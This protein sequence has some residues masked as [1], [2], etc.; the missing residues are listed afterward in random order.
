MQSIKVDK[1]KLITT[2]EE[3]RTKHRKI[4]E[5]ACEGYQKAVI[6]ELEAQLKR[7]KEGIRRSMLISI[8]APV[9]QTKEYDRAIGMLKMSVDTEVLLSERDYQ[10]Y[11][12]DDWDWKQKF[13]TSSRP[14]SQAA[15]VM[16]AAQGEIE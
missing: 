11:V 8:P 5:E 7:A 9:D 15:Q 14:Y 13:L 2:L 10:C 1:A 16:L 6:K 3:N 12:L 4:F